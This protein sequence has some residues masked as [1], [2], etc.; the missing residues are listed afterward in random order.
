MEKS[1]KTYYL[2][3]FSALADVSECTW[4]VEFKYRLKFLQA[5]HADTLLNRLGRGKLG[6][7]Q[8]EDYDEDARWE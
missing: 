2:A 1:G 7:S 4:T 6:E 3:G 8:E 5:D